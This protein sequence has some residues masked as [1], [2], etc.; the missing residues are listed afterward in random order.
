MNDAELARLIEYLKNI[1]G[2]TDSE[3]V[4]LLH[5]IASGKEN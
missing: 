3:I 2:W 4:K 5:F 1:K